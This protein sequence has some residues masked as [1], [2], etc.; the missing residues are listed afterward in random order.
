[1]KP[2]QEMNRRP[3]TPRKKSSSEKSS[4]QHAVEQRAY[5][6]DRKRTQ[7]GDLRDGVRVAAQGAS[8]MVQTDASQRACEHEGSEE[9]G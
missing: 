5:Q 1:M 3:T 9:C 4:L 6:H 7:P 8:P 2:N